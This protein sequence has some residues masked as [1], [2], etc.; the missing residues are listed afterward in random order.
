MPLKSHATAARVARV[1]D[2]PAA[3]VRED[4]QPRGAA[5]TKPPADEPDPATPNDV[6]EQLKQE[7]ESDQPDTVEDDPAGPLAGTSETPA[8][9]TATPATTARRGRPPRAT[10]TTPVEGEAVSA[11]SLRARQKE[12]EQQVRELHAAEA[13]ELRR[14]ANEFRGKRQQLEGE[15]RTVSSAL[16][17]AIF[18]GQ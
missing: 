9:V 15:Y 18:N 1:A 2:Q 5:V 16:T 12:I 3:D 17:T 4:I 7:A 11:A 10:A 6:A 14:I 13:S 8:P